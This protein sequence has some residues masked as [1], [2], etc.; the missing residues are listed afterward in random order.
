MAKWKKILASTGLVDLSEA[1]KRDIAEAERKEQLEKRGSGGNPTIVSP[2]VSSVLPFANKS[3]PVT[4]VTSNETIDENDPEVKKYSA[5]FIELF[6]KVN[7]PGPDYL[8]F[9]E[10][11]NDLQAHAGL[12]EIQAFKSAS[13]SLKIKKDTLVSSI[14]TYLKI[15]NE[16]NV[17]FQ[18]KLT[19][20]S[21]SD[22]AN[23]KSEIN[24]LQTDNANKLAQIRQI[25]ESIDSNTQKIEVLTNSITEE[26]NKL[27]LKSAIYEREY[28]KHK[29]KL[30]AD[31][32][33][34]TSQ[35]S[36]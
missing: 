29:E 3:N 26:E 32:E 16:D 8:E 21:N 27:K 25:Q 2:E 11:V 31:L 30:Q 36:N 19:D 9:I 1:E 12:T 24:S 33:K 22:M 10:S 6:K 23:K 14:T 13:I 15:L 35:I 17:T 7:L 34:I 5:Y 20:K 4:V 28:T 18:K